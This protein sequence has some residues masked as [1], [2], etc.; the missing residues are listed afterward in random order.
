MM[1]YGD[2]LS[3]VDLDKLYK[4]HKNSN[5]LATLTAVK[6]LARFGALDLDQEG[7]VNNFIEKPVN[8]SGCINGGF[9][10]LSEK[11]INFIHSYD[12]A[13][14]KGPISRLV[15]ENQL[16]AYKHEGFWQPMDT[17]REKQI[18]CDMWEK[19][20]APWKVFKRKKNIISLKKVV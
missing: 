9:F 20:I 10:V 4:F 19:G 1:T 3:N 8:E 7:K 12:E 18:L 6:P 14:E 16:I 11:A 2:G 15:R 5:K 17:L 13:W